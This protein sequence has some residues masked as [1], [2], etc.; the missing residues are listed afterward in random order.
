MRDS[1]T[2]L[3]LTRKLMTLLFSTEEMATCSVRGKTKRALNK[4]KMEAIIGT[5]L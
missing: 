2:A 3:S 1:K 5:T 4:P